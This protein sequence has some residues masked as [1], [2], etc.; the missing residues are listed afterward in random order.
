MRR[1]AKAAL[2]FACAAVLTA[3]VP[4]RVPQTE[5][6]AENA[7]WTA[8]GVKVPPGG[9]VLPQPYAPPYSTRSFVVPL[10]WYRAFA[11]ELK[12][13]GDVPVQAS[14]LREDLPVLRFLMQKTY[15]GYTT[16]QTRHHWNWDKW[17][18]QWD[19]ALAAKGGAKLPLS[20]AFAPW[21]KLED[22]QLDNHSGISGYMKFTSGS[23]SAQLAR[24]PAGACTALRTSAGT[25]GLARADNGQQ[26]HAVQQWNG[27]AFAPAW[28]VSYPVRNGSPVSIRCG[29]ASIELQR[30]ESAAGPQTPGYEMLAA[31]IAYVRMPSFADAP[32]DAL[33][34]SLAKAQ[35]LGKERAVIFD[36]RGNEGGNAPSDLLSNWFAQSAVDQAAQ[37]RQI[38]TES[39]FRTALFFGLQQQLTN[40][41]KPPVPSG[42][43]QFLQ[44]IVDTLKAPV[45]CSPSPSISQDGTSLTDHHFSRTGEEGQ[46]RIIA[47]VDNGCGSDCEYMTAILAGLPGTVIAGSS[48]YGVMGFTQPGYFVLPHSR[49]PFRLALSRTDAYGDDRSVDGYGITVDVLLTTRAAQ[50]KSSLL[51]L[52]RAL[53]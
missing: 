49:V 13:N 18:A 30:I 41:L 38:G 26:P 12:T 25:I 47:L 28:Y 5:I 53:L 51:A 27:S 9:I 43:T 1:F 50:E 2:A 42:A 36:L 32:V 31:G 8:L 37:L 44:Q 29:G 34:A 19:A 17:F 14:A 16:A 40:G 15:A 6:D 23:Q 39:C 3:A 21:G 24:K 20:Q 35:N 48:T 52:A 46:T 22:V 33:R 11:Q 10:E 7:R 45:S 4:V